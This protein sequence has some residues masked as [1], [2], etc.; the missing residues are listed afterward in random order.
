[1]S[2]LEQLQELYNADP[3][4]E[5]ISL[6]GLQLQEIGLEM[7]YV[8]LHFS[9]VRHLDLSAN[10]LDA[11]PEDFGQQ[12]PKLVALDLTLNR[13]RSIGD[14][15]SVLQQC[16]SL[17]SLSVTLKNSTEEKVLR[18]ML[19]RLRI[20][21]GTPLECN[22]NAPPLPPPSPLPVSAAA[23]L[24][25]AVNGSNSPPTTPQE[26][27]TLRVQYA[28]LKQD[29][30]Q[31]TEERV[32]N[33]GRAALAQLKAQARATRGSKSNS[34]RPTE[35]PASIT[36]EKTDWCK[37]LKSA[38]QVSTAAANSR[39]LGEQKQLQDERNTTTKAFLDQLKSAVK[40]FHQCS[41]KPIE[42]NADQ[43]Q[44]YEKLDQHM[45]LLA[46]QLMKQEQEI[47]RKQA[48]S[49]AASDTADQKIRMLQA[50]WSLLEVCG[51]FGVEKAV[52]LN[53]TLGRAFAALLQMQ[54][55]LVSA[56][57]HQ[58]AVPVAP[59]AS[60]TASRSR[61]STNSDS[62]SSSPKQTEADKR[63]Q[64]QIKM[65]LEVA[66]SL[67]N[68]VEAI[69]TSLQQEKAKHELL[70][71]ENWTLKHENET[72]KRQQTLS[73]PSLGA[74]RSGATSDSEASPSL[75]RRI[76]KRNGDSALDTTTSTINIRS[77]VEKIASTNHETTSKS[78][79]ESPVT[80]SASPS[81]R[82]D[83]LRAATA[84]EGSNATLRNLTLKQ[85]VD[86]IHCII[87]SKVKYDQRTSDL[88]APRETMEQH[89]YTYLNQRFGLHAL[90]VDYASAIWKAC[91]AFAKADNDVAVFQALLRNQLDEG[92]LTVKT[93]LRQA[94][95]DLLRAYFVSRYPLKQEAAIMALIKQ[96][97]TTVLH[98]EEWQEL[99]TYLYDP[100][101]VHSFSQLLGFFSL[102]SNLCCCAVDEPRA[103]TYCVWYGE[104]RKHC[105]QNS[106][107]PRLFLL[108]NQA[109]FRSWPLSRFS[110]TTRCKADS[111]CWRGSTRS[112]TP[113]TRSTWASS[114]AYVY[115]SIAPSFWLVGFQILWTDVVD[116]R[117]E[118]VHCNRPTSGCQQG[119]PRSWPLDLNVSHCSPCTTSLTH[120]YSRRRWWTK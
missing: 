116:H 84:A 61:K 70:A 24:H 51:L 100:Q 28:T 81:K 55:E 41:A 35:Q 72:L 33:T 115:H 14:L 67:E 107:S 21:N 47:A 103:P 1:M 71:Q 38:E 12:L 22:P 25:E 92:F 75:S 106:P 59:T 42:E 63:Q 73:K 4:T 16:G 48:S 89:M 76:R 90:V 78:P 37:L 29:Q 10:E 86:L 39:D 98:E 43:P 99:L 118:C 9:H 66:E 68:D 56:I 30:R 87:A 88:R 112:S 113:T 31:L 8:Q 6:R 49:A 65:L 45:D 96:R 95:L 74:R 102:S 46:T 104:K 69:Q 58:A 26:K 36:D 62:L 110:T 44:L 80:R 54:Q 109:R 3:D 79:S 17:K 20:L 32:H 117:I 2:A 53:E 50:R 5:R 40:M 111:S 57:S 83:Q 120:S 97:T 13:F 7:E 105:M 27:R 108:S 18:V 15:A 19:P 114:S 60:D 34:V 91:A 52:G 23:A 11:L 82:Q 94:V 85:L 77:K 119:N 93:K 101:D 64:Q